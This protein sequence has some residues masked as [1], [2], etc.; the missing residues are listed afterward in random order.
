MECYSWQ[1]LD[2]GILPLFCPLP[3]PEKMKHTVQ[4]I[5]TNCNP[6]DYPSF[7]Y[8]VK[9]QVEYGKNNKKT[10]GGGGI[11]TLVPQKGVNGFRDRR[12]RPLCHPSEGET[13]PVGA[14]NALAES[15]GFEPWRRFRRLHDFQSCSF[16]H[17]DNSPYK[18]HWS[19]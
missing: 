12:I 17:S 6:Y 5:C 3:C 19:V 7:F 13:A 1:I 8:S 15:Q 10:G 14:V 2:K 9:Q 18:V 16:G 4:A 11:R